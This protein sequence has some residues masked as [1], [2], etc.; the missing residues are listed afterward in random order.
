MLSGLNNG[1]LRRYHS[2]LAVAQRL[3]DT[4]LVFVILLS[5]CMFYGVEF[6]L[7]YQL[8]AVLGAVFTWVAMGVVDAYRQWRGASLWPQL[9]VLIVGWSLVVVLL[10]FIAW[11][12]KQGDEFSRTVIGVW[13][14]IVPV[15]LS[16]VHTISRIFLRKIRES[17][18]NS[19]QV[20]IIGAGDL[21]KLLADRIR[22]SEWM[23]M[24]IRGF[25]DDDENKHGGGVVGVPVLGATK[26]VYAYVKDQGI[27]HVY[28]ALPMRAE[29]QMRKVFDQLQDTTASLFLIP[30]LFVFE[31]LGAREQN[32]AGLPAFAL[33][34]TPLTGPFG[35]L[36][37]FEDIVLSLFILI[38]ISPLLLII[39][40]AVKLTS[41][42][43]IVFKQNRYGLHGEKIKVYKFRSMTVC[44]NDDTV[45][46]QAGKGDA[47]I[48]PLGVFLRR[49]SLDE[50][51]QFFNVLQGRMS[52]VGPRPHAVAHNEEYRKLIKGYMWR[53]KMKPGITGWAQINGWRGETDTLE[54]MEKRV[55]YDLEYICCWSIWFDL[56]IVFLTIFKGFVNKNAY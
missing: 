14:V 37:R 5:L 8:I 54:K 47:R 28:F 12:T 39:A 4:A 49:T 6:T 32:I 45:I 21:G 17:G 51:P 42:G 31:L 15:I 52:V 7:G 19:R 23:G 27:D 9:R 35:M 48:T 13:F 10:L 56:K 40:L 41:A 16:I 33:C 50:L 53:H 36:K 18:H 30:D 38:L 3:F 44:D 43:S 34:E 2:W 46:K 20:V 25:F 22:E 26:D 55:E 24:D 29:S 1:T 11:A